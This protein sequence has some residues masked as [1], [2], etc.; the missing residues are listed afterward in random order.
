MNTAELGAKLALLKEMKDYHESMSEILGSEISKLSMEAYKQMLET[1]MDQMR[2]S[3]SLFKDQTP[4]IITPNS[5]YKPTVIKQPEFFDYLRDSSF[6]DMIKPTV[7]P[8]TLEA[9]VTS[10]KENNLP[11]PAEDVLKVFTIE[12][13]SVRRAPKSS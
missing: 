5:K 9:W 1:N 8:K 10:Q 6:G 12:T 3:G 2:V 4:R 7:H 13:V 11:L